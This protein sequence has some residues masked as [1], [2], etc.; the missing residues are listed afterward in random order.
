MLKS[1]NTWVESA[2]SVLKKKESLSGKDEA[3]TVTGFLFLLQSCDMTGWVTGR[4]SFR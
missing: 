2:M 4:T 3:R 1:N